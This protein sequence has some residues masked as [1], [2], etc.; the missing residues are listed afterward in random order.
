LAKGDG[1]FFKEFARAPGKVGSITPSSKF[2]AEEM[3][4]S[5]AIGSGDVVVEL[6]AGTG[7]VTRHIVDA[8]DGNP[9]LTLEPNAEMAQV[10][11]SRLPEVE[12]VEGFAQNL[13][14]LLQDWG[15]PKADRVISSLPFAAW[16]A[17][18]QDEVIAAIVSSMNP[19]GRLVTFTYLHSQLLPGAVRLRKKLKQAFGTVRK[20]KP[21]LANVP[22]AFVYICD[23]AKPY[24]S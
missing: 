17:S 16:P 23:H 13:P 7:P 14:G 21:I 1:T 15:H 20:S 18:V 3:I 22:P 19:G 12:V 10:V 11:R 4:E 9:F 8:L 6:G 24:D 5:V 2:L